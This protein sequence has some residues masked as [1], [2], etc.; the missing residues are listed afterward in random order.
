MPPQITLKLSVSEKRHGAL[1]KHAVLQSATRLEHQHLVSIYYDTDDLRLR[2]AG[3][4]LRLR[5]NGE[6]WS[7]TVKRQDVTQGGLTRRLEWHDPYLGRFDF[8]V[9]DDAGLQKWLQ[10]PKL[11][12]KLKAIF[13]TNFHRSIW[14]LEPRH[15]VKILAKLDQGSVIAAGRRA[16]ISELELQLLTG[17]LDELYELA[18]Q[19]AQKEALPL[20]PTAKSER[21]YQ[22][23]LNQPRQAVKAG[24]LTIDPRDTPLEAFRIIALA[25]FMQLQLN[26]EGAILTDDPEYVHQMR[27][28]MRRL[29]AA[30]RM[31][32]PVLPTGF[33]EHLV[34]LLRELMQQL[35][36]ARDLD[37]LIAEIVAPVAQALPLEPRLMELTNAIT[38]RLF[39]VRATTRAFLQRPAYGQRLLMS[40]QWLNSQDFVK[41]PDQAGAHLSLLEFANKRLHRLLRNVLALANAACVE[42]PASL[43]SLRIGIKRLRYGIEFFGHMIPGNKGAKIVMRLAGLQEELG[44]LNDLASAGILLMECAGNDVQLREAVTLIGGW[45]GTHHK[46]LLDDVPAKLKFIRGLKIPHLACHGS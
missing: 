22:L 27:V 14:Q 31:F 4:I 18:L 41:P 28:A 12:L 2:N 32:N 17:N 16:T 26:S 40:T 3:I 42:D 6:S 37:V 13:E 38:N 44:Q 25:S 8:S 9:I 1:H 10:R 43:H 35:G 39:D 29:R 7:Q 23:F 15:G 20:L 11:E 5:R 34:P 30:M 21:G 19:L 45:H 36:Q 46:A 33:A 24:P